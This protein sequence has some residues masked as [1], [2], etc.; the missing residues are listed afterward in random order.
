MKYGLLAF[1]VLSLNMCITILVKKL[2]NIHMCSDRTT[3]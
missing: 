3:I 1:A 2:C